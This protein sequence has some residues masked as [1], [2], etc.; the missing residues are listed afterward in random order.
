MRIIAIIDD[1]GI[2]ERILKHLS[3]WDTQLSEDCVRLARGN[4]HSAHAVRL[5][6][7]HGI[8][9]FPRNA[10]LPTI[11]ARL[12]ACSYLQSIAGRLVKN[13]AIDLHRF[14]NPVRG[15]VVA[16]SHRWLAVHAGTRATRRTHM[17]PVRWP[18]QMTALPDARNFLRWRY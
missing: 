2:M 17:R 8:A 18:V 7:D 15:P 14:T 1:A 9:A 13:Q 11:Q 3:V 16:A 5:C 12:V 10:R 6:F 4:A